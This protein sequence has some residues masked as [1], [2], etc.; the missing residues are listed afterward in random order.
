MRIPRIN[1]TTVAESLA[2]SNPYGPVF[3]PDGSI[4]SQCGERLVAPRGTA[5]MV[6]RHERLGLRPG[7]ESGLRRGG[8]RGGA[9]PA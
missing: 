6:E 1:W 5:E 2:A 4:Y 9:L 7:G 8:A 3:M